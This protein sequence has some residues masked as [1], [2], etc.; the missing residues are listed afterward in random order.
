[1]TTDHKISKARLWTSYVLQGLIVLLFFMGAAGNIFQ[2][3]DAVTEAVKL[4]YAE[5]S[6][7]C[8][9]IALFVSTLL[10][11]IPRTAIIGAVLLT[12]WLGG[13]VATHMINQ[14]PMFNMLLPVIFGIVIWLALW[15]RMPSL[16]RMFPLV[17]KN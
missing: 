15:L 4:G 1:M 8:L 11:A 17:S 12:A 6:V 14:D 2:S 10:Y 16:Q 13:A 3:E 5:S 9:G 7:L